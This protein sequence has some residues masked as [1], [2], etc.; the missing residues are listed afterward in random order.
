MQDFESGQ[1]VAQVPDFDAKTELKRIIVMMH[2]KSKELIELHKRQNL[3][4]NE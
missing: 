2:N 4:P 3:E 1:H